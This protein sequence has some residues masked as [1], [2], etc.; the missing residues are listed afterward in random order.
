MEDS[1]DSRN[2][3]HSGEGSTR[4]AGENPFLRFAFTPADKSPALYPSLGK[5]KHHDDADSNSDTQKARKG[6]S[7]SGSKRVKVYD[8]L[9]GIEDHLE[10]GLDVIFCGIN[11]G[12]QSAE[13]GHHYGNPT[14]HFW[15]CLHESGFTPRKL[16][17]RE[18]VKLPKEFFIGLVRFYTLYIDCNRGSRAD[19]LVKSSY[20]RAK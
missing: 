13:I 16:D 15:S 14:N 1:V 4:T 6:P 9:Q 5:R 10:P 8:H 7:V 12:Q 19:K 11:P 17:P 2:S 18:D 3:S 20:N